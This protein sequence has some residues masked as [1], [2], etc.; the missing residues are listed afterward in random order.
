M[1]FVRGIE[2]Y[3]VVNLIYV[4]VDDVRLDFC[5]VIYNQNVVYIPCVQ[6]YVLC[7]K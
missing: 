6:C 5:C 2:F 4:C 1:R 3:V 7:V